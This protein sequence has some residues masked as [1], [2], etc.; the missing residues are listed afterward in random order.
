MAKLMTKPDGLNENILIEYYNFILEKDYQDCDF[1]EKQ[2][3]QYKC[4]HIISVEN[5]QYDNITVKVSF[6]LEDD[7][8]RSVTL[9]YER[10]YPFMMNMERN[11][12]LK[13]ILSDGN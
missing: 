8:L 9:I 2:K 4:P 11:R 3:E 13:Y 5:V 10:I 6:K 7:K 12:K 1:S